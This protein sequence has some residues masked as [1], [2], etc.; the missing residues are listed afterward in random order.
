VRSVILEEVDKVRD[1]VEVIYSSDLE[2]LRVGN[3]CAEH[4]T[5]DSAETI[6]TE[7]D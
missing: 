3:G 2:F 5:P 6:D 4:E 1:L 7:I